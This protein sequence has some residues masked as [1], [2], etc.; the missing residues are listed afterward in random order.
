[1][2]TIEAK[3]SSLE[4]QGTLDFMKMQFNRL[5]EETNDTN[6]DRDLKALDS[7]MD[8]L[9][10]LF[11]SVNSETKEQKKIINKNSKDIEMC[12]N[13]QKASKLRLAGC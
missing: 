4:L 5:E 12:K 2:S 1:M 7:N 8:S 9:G 13:S 10:K 6:I 3:I 11:D